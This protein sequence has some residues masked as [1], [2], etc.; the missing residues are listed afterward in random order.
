MSNTGQIVA[1]IPL[2]NG[3][4][5]QSISYLYTDANGCEASAKD[6][7]QV[8]ICTGITVQGVTVFSMHPRY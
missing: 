1:I 6:T 8:N 7:I 4:G 3:A 5:T 2:K